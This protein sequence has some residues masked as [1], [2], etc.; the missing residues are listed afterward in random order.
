MCALRDRVYELGDDLGRASLRASRAGTDGISVAR[1]RIAVGQVFRARDSEKAADQRN[2]AAD[3][4][5]RI[6]DVASDSL[7]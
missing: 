4:F 7:G 6:A 2:L 5:D 1:M 3:L